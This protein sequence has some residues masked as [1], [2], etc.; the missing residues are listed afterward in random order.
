M[1][2]CDMA[3]GFDA[4]AKLSG[5]M[6][7]SESFTK[8]FPGHQF[9]RST[10][11]ENRQRWMA[12]SGGERGALVAAGRTTGGLWTR[13]PSV[14]SVRKDKRQPKLVDDVFFESK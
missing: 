4:M 2:A 11:D 6:S 1:Y 12:L 10:F 7:R 5:S 3:V 13:V 8:A 9:K 14:G